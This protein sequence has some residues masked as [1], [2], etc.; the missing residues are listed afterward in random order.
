VLARGAAAYAPT[1]GALV[2]TVAELVGDSPRR[3]QLAERGARLARPLA[4]AEIAANVLAR[5]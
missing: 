1:P 2:Q 5:L 3:E 4:A